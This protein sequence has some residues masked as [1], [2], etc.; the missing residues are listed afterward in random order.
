LI[1]DGS[2]VRDQ[3]QIKLHAYKFYKDLFG[4]GGTTWGSFNGALWNDSENVSS[5]MNSF[6]IVPFTME[7][8][9]LVVFGMGSDKAPGSDD[10]S[11]IFYQTYWDVVKDDIFSMF[12]DFYNGTLDIAKL[13]RVIIYL[14]PKILNAT[15][16]TEFRPIGLLNRSY[17]FFS[18][19]LANRL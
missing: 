19:V 12:T 17:N 16:I 6:L 5:D 13:N 2:E 11:M 8:V 7:E 15:L 14:I 9:K 1:I 18:K 3:D 4:R 10:F